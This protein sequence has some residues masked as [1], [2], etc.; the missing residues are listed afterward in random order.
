M[1]S[2]ITNAIAPAAGPTTV[3]TPVRIEIEY[4]VPVSAVGLMPRPYRWPFCR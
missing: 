1:P 3:A 4:S 2:S